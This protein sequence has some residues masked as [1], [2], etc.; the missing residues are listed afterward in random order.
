MEDAP[1]P[2]KPISA[3]RQK[4][5]AD[6][7]AEL[8]KARKRMDPGILRKIKDIVKSSPEIMKKLGIKPSEKIDEDMPLSSKGKKQPEM[9][10]SK[11][12]THSPQEKYEKVDQAKNMEI[13]AKLIQMK[14]GAQDD[15]KAVIKKSQK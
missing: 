1:P 9:M 13:M 12:Q 4:I 2:Q 5:L 14:P 15:I 8:R 11:P 10:T 6:A 3:K 7:F